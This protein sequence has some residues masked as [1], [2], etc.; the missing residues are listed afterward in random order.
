VTQMEEAR[1]VPESHAAKKPGGRQQAMLAQEGGELPQRNGEAD[2][3][4][5]PKP[6]LD[7]EPSDVVVGSF[8]PDP[9]ARAP[10]VPGYRR[11][12]PR[13]AD[14]AAYQPHRPWT[15]APGGVEDEQRRMPGCGVRYGFTCHTG[16]VKNWVSSGRPPPMSPPTKLGLYR[17]KSA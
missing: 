6:P 2:E 5:E 1:R 17:S 13:N 12:I 3:I 9:H 8:K 10:R 14:R 11:R 4:G 7:H 16:R 15:P